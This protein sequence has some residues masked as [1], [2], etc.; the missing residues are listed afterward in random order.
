MSRYENCTYFYTLY[1]AVNNCFPAITV[2][3]V[4]TIL[5]EAILAPSDYTVEFNDFTYTQTEIYSLIGHDLIQSCMSEQTK[6]KT[7]IDFIE[8]ASNVIKHMNDGYVSDNDFAERTSFLEDTARYEFILFSAL[9]FLKTAREDNALL[10]GELKL[11]IVRFREINDLIQSYTRDEKNID[12]SREEFEKA[13]PIYRMLK[14]LQNL[15]YNYNLST[16]ERSGLG[17]EHEDDEDLTDM[18]NYANWIKRIMLLQLRLEINSDEDAGS[19]SDN[20]YEQNTSLQLNKEEN[21]LHKISHLRG[22]NDKRGFDRDRFYM[23][24]EKNK[25]LVKDSKTEN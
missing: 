13:K 15:G 25:S 12:I 22:V 23:L 1:N 11:N 4:H 14:S 19:S 18:F 17:I 8:N 6:E 20:A 9:A 10:Y 7:Y 3:D 5:R 16:K 2:S 24:E 21:I